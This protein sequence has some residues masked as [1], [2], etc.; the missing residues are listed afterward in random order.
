MES[1]T[2]A[3]RREQAPGDGSSSRPAHSSRPNAPAAGSTQRQQERGRAEAQPAQAPGEAHLITAQNLLDQQQQ[4]ASSETVQ[5]FA[6]TRREAQGLQHNAIILSRTADKLSTALDDALRAAELCDQA[7]A[8]DQA[9][10]AQAVQQTGSAS[11]GGSAGDSSLKVPV[12]ASDVARQQARLAAQPSDADLKIRVEKLQSVLQ[13]R[14]PSM[15]VVACNTMQVV[16]AVQTHLI[17]YGSSLQDSLQLKGVERDGM[18]I[19][20][21]VAMPQHSTRS[22]SLSGLGPF[23]NPVAASFAHDAALHTIIEVKELPRTPDAAEMRR[24]WAEW[25]NFRCA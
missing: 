9:A 23:D 3:A 18:R 22:W 14:P 16:S 12:S 20:A 6:S 8:A 7:S 10:A 13:G 21:H 17:D 11:A 25:R 15:A 1:P 24:K 5:A 19:R 4:H 2:K